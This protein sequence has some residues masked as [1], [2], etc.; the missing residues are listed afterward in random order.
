MIGPREPTPRRAAAAIEPEGDPG[1]VRRLRRYVPPVALPRLDAGQGDWLAE[2]RT[3]TVIFANVHGSTETTPD[4]IERLQ[5]V[6]EAAQ[7]IVARFDGWL[8]EITI[9]DKGTTLVAAFGVPPFS[10]E[11]DPDRAVQAALGFQTEIRALGLTAGIGIATGPAFCGPVGNARRRDFVVLGQHVNL[12]A[13]LMQASG[14]DVVLCDAQTRLGAHGQASFQRLPAYVLKGMATPIDVYRTRPARAGARPALGAHR[15]DRG[16]CGRGS[17]PRRA[18]RRN[19]LA[20]RAR[21]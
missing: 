2:L 21:R 6:T 11:D 19:R 10:H 15:P 12:A 14:R 1:Q 17:R 18:R 3:T 16:A 20:H 9:D 7:R 8:K 4:A 5:Q 13:R